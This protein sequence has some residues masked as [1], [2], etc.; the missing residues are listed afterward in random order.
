MALPARF[1]P[2]PFALRVLLILVLPGLVAGAWLYRSLAAS[3]P[4]QTVRLT[5]GVSAPVLIER[6][7]HGVP[8]VTARTDEDAAFAVGYA[9]A[10]DRLWQLEVQRRLSQ[11][12]T[13]EIFGPE[14]VE[15][16]IWY[17]TLGL[18]AAASAAWPHLSRPAQRSLEA[19]ARGINARLADG[20]PLPPEFRFFGLVPEPWTPLDSLTWMKAFAFDL[21]GNF[22]REMHFSVARKWLSP[23]QVAPLFP[24]YDMASPLPGAEPQQ[25]AGIARVAARRRSIAGLNGTSA[26]VAG[27]NAWVVSGRLTANGAPILVNDPHLSLQ[28][29]SLWYAQRVASPGWTAAGMAVVGLPLVIFGRNQQI[30]WGGTNLTADTQD[31]YLERTDPVGRRYAAG[32]GWRDL[33]RRRERI[34]IRPKMP[35]RLHR[36]YK[37]VSLTV[38]HTARG[39]IVSDHKGV[40]DQ[41]V[42]LRWTGLAPDDTS[43]EAFFRLNRAGDWQAFRRALR[44]LVAPTLNLLY[45]DRGGRIGH[46]A[47]GRVPIRGSGAG[48]APAPGWNPG[49]DWT[50]FVPFEQ[51]PS[52]FDPPEGF[53]VNANNQVGGSRYPH[54]LS[55]DWASPARAQRIEN[56]LRARLAGGRRLDLADMAKIQA[57]TVDLDAASMMAALRPYLVRSG[58]DD[59]AVALLAGWQGNMAAD[60]SAAALF[61]SWMRHLRD[62]LFARQSGGPLPGSRDAAML[63]EIGW[64]SDLRAIR[65]AIRAPDAA[66]CGGASNSA[67]APILLRALDKAQWELFK[68]RGTWSTSEWKW[69]DVHATDYAHLP[70]TTIKPLNGLFDRR[71][72]NGGSENAINVA[73]SRYRDSEGYLQNFGPG[74][75]QIIALGPRRTDHLYMISTGQSGNVMSAHYDDMIGPFR[76]V[77]FYRLDPRERESRR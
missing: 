77:Q 71:I 18:R 33:G 39:P 2:S 51:L 63:K 69:G 50:G 17:R 13:A 65:A 37:P 46:Q 55:S 8:T 9:H 70:F 20:T 4:P 66:W 74:F 3:L 68:L 31:L 38:R 12:R 76:R 19:Y 52:R 48:T 57:D 43:Y 53:L 15:S 22:E 25:T 64:A 72:G 47:A 24:G 40:L 34:A 75:R 59:R 14:G 60:S 56:L 26:A 7:D 32:D 73:S 41:P 21:G 6:D 30:A 5:Q 44:L 23:A 1:R 58:G 16:D 29:P 35:A 67:C 10:Q 61:Q 28:I 54:H 11:G 45:A 42:A 49:W 36:P 27:S 62:E